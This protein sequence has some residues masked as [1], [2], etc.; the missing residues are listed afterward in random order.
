MDDSWQE[1]LPVEY[2]HRVVAPIAFERH[3][4]P[5]ANAEK[6]IGFDPHGQ[7]C[8]Y[9]HSFLMTEEGFDVD[10]FPIL[11]EVYYERVVAWRLSAGG[12]IQIK[13]YSDRLDQCNRHL[14]T[15][16]VEM[17]DNAPR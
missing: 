8:F 13:S 14:T 3:K 4:E 2:L 5:T 6:V 15:L 1:L 10:E 16:P 17:T 12:W 9:F 7:R 11:V